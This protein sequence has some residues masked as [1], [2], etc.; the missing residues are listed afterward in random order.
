MKRFPVFLIILCGALL[1]ASFAAAKAPPGKGKPDDKEKEKSSRTASTDPATC[2]PKISIILKG[3]FV[4]GGGSS[5]TMNVK[6][7]NFHGRDLVGKPLTLGVNAGTKFRRH[8]KADL[9]DFKA[10][11]RL[12]V[13][14]RACKKPKDDAGSAATGQLMASR[15]VGQPAKADADDEKK[16]DDDKNE[17]KDK[18]EKDDD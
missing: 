10:D 7:S 15:V 14:A 13:Q 12:N 1:A 3:T 11:D 16:D 9:S 17:K 2:K 6:H 8:G 4:S 18:D 5:F